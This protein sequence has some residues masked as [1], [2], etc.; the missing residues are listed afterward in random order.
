M[1]LSQAAQDVRRNVFVLTGI[2]GAVLALRDA[3]VGRFVE[4]P[5]DRDTGLGPGKR[6]ARAAVNAPA[7]RQVLAR[8]LA[9]GVER[10]GI[11]E[12]ARVAISGTVEHHHRFAGAE[13]G[14]ADDGR[15]ARQS[16]VALDRTLDA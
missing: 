11:I 9:G 3:D 4:E 14:L 12:A 10:V 1:Q 15:Y 7:E 2:R 13:I 5:L 16:E 8:V 6:G